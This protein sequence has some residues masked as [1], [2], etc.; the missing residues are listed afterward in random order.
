MR[1]EMRRIN[2]GRMQRALLYAMFAAIPPLILAADTNDNMI[3]DIFGVFDYEQKEIIPQTGLF[4]TTN[5]ESYGYKVLQYS[6]GV[7]TKETAYLTDKTLAGER[8][9]NPESKTSVITTYHTNGAIEQ[10]LNYQ[11]GEPRGSQISWDER[12]ILISSNYYDGSEHKIEKAQ[13]GGPAYP[14]QGVGS[15]DP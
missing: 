10:V 15:A 13:Q 2:I 1:K 7:M 12:G 14:P 4:A 9:I 3:A 5:Y 11:N 6:N 8:T